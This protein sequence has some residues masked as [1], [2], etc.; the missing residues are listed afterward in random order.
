[1]TTWGRVSEN[2]HSWAATTGASVSFADTS[3]SVVDYTIVS[4]LD[5]YVVGGYVTPYDVSSKPTGYVVSGS[6]QGWE[7]VSATPASWS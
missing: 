7:V 6:E 4:S 3:G 2:D 5:G 1:M